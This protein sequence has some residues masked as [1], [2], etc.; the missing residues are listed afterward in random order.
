MTERWSIAT[1]GGTI[2]RNGRVE[3]HIGLYGWL[4][5]PESAAGDR[6]SPRRGQN[7]QRNPGEKAATIHRRAR[8]ADRDQSQEIEVQQIEGVGDDCDT[9]DSARLA[10]P[11]GR[12]EI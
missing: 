5:E 7:P 8:K 11:V 1:E 9:A 2:I 3:I 12:E 4:D 6:I 10:S